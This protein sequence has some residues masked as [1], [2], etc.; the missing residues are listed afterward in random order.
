MRKQG[1]EH[2]ERL[3]FFVLVQLVVV[4]KLK[5]VK[6][7]L[8]EFSE[9]GALLLVDGGLLLRDVLV[10]PLPRSSFIIG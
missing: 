10:K 4:E 2:L 1:H 3:D 7:E 6:A 5:D 8:E 9:E